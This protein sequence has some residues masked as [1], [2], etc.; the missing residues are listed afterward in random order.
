LLKAAERFSLRKY[1]WIML[2]SLGVK[3]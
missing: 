1:S 3:M 2:S